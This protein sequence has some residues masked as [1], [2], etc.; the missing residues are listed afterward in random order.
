[1]K[2]RT[3]GPRLATLSTARIKQ[4]PGAAV[5]RKRGSAGVRDRHAIRAR[6]CDLCQ[7]CAEQGKTTIGAAVDHKVPLWAGGS[8]APDNK[9]VLCDP[10]HEAKSKRE[11][12]LRATGAWIG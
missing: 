5:E 7:I 11:A 3:L 4:A 12:A 8:D 2:L 9:W 6:D 1:M 10:C